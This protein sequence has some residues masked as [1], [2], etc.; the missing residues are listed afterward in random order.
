MRSLSVI[1]FCTLALSG[2]DV[3][4]NDP[5]WDFFPDMFYSTAYESYSVNP[6]FSNHMT[7]RTPPPGTVPRDFIP[8]EY[9]ADAEGRT[10]AGNELS[11]PFTPSPENIDRGRYSFNIFC[12][13]CHNYTGDGNGPLFTSGLYPMKPRPV[14]GKTAENLKDGEIYHTITL[15]LGSMGPYGS[16]VRP[17]DRWKVVLYI[18][19]LQKDFSPLADSSQIKK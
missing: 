7:M 3:G 18:R 2:C 17:D 16:Q 14:V 9:T 10:R 19:K 13:L 15:G 5:G 1:L 8:F 12:A 11:N 4:R 6:N